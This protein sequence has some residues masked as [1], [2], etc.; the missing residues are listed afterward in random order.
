MVN[1]GLNMLLCGG[2]SRSFGLFIYLFG[3]GGGEVTELLAETFR[4][5]KVPGPLKEI[6]QSECEFSSHRFQSCCSQA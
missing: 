4:S 2:K 6:K 5:E 3:E 1:T